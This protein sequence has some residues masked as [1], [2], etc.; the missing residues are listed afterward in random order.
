MEKKESSTQKKEY[1]IEFECQ[2]E[3]AWHALFGFALARSNRDAIIELITSI[4]LKKSEWEYLKKQDKVPGSL[5][6]D[7]VDEI[8]MHLCKRNV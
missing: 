8:N 6:I 7:L 1:G 3:M 4:G 2:I 5:P